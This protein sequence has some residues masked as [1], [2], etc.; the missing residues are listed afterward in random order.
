MAALLSHQPVPRGAARRDPDQ[1]R[2]SGHPG[3]RC[4]R[5]EWAG[6]AAARAT[7]TRAELRS[8]LPAAASVGNPVDM[9]ASAPADH[10]RRALAA[11]LRD[12]SVDSVIAIFIPPLVTEP[13]AVAAAIAEGARGEPGKPVLGVFMRAEGAPAALAPDSLLRVP[14]IGGAG[15]RAS[16]H[17]R[18]VARAGRVEP[19]RRRS[20]GSTATAIRPIVERVLGR[21]GGWTTADEAAALLDRRG[22]PVCAGSR[23]ATTC[24]R[25]QCSAAAAIGYPVALKALGPT[26]LHKTERRAVSPEPRRMT[27]ALRAAFE[28]FSSRFGGEMTSVLVQRMVP[29][30]RR[31]DRRRA[32]GSAVRTADRLRNRRRARRPAGRQRVP[33]APA[34]RVGRRRDDRR[35][36]RRAAAARL[37]RRA[38]GRRSRRCAT[39]CCGSRSW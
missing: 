13:D 1:R 19:R 3:G 38:A 17:L 37:P 30:G 39:C 4:V 31:D 10:Y 16:H 29:R 33:A 23:V 15:A 9:L 5:G 11:I 28:D 2:R 22:H 32:A 18:R 6:A 14:G 25:A 20:I 21:G 7:T 36:A 35:A 24:G 27:P 12:E 26:L 8:F 34:D